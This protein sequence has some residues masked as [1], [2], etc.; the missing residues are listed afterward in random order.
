MDGEDF[1]S[2]YTGGLRDGFPENQLFSVIF[3]MLYRLVIL[4]AYVLHLKIKKS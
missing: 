1:T 3:F 4:I 2:Q